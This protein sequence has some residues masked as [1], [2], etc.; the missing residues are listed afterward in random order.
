VLI[1][2]LKNDNKISQNGLIIF[3]G[4]SSTRQKTKINRINI[5]QN[6]QKK[7]LTALTIVAMLN[8]YDAI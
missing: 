6:Y 3:H 5:R 8:I 1:F 4:F 7:Y 2:Y